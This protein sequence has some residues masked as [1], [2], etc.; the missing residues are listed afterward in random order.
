MDAQ[1][2]YSSQVFILMRK[3]WNDIDNLRSPANSH[4]SD[5]IWN[6]AIESNER[7]KIMRKFSQI[8][9]QNTRISVEK[10]R[11]ACFVTKLLLMSHV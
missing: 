10:C 7:M 9:Y 8:T 6:E 1:R 2:I 4:R 11:N 5:D 3:L